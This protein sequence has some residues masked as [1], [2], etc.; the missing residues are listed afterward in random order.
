MGARCAAALVATGR[1]PYMRR[2]YAAGGGG[3][4]LRESGRR[5]SRPRSRSAAATRQLNLKDLRPI[6]GSNL[7][8]SAIKKFAIGEVIFW[9]PMRGCIGRDRSRILHAAGIG[10]CVEITLVANLFFGR[11][12]S[13]IGNADRA[14]IFFIVGWR[15]LTRIGT[16]ACFAAAGSARIVGTENTTSMY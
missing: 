13:Q 7:R 11:R 3:G 14:Q 16:T 10:R 2:V 6:R 15:F 5:V 12:F 9:G 1:E 8:R 4:N